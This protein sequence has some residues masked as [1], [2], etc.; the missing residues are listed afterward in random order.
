[1]RKRS[2]VDAY[3]NFQ[4]YVT[5]P[6]MYKLDVFNSR[7]YFE[8]VIVYILSDEVYRL[9]EHEPSERLPAMADM[10]T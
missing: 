9:L 4:V 7:F 2:F 6:G 5:E 1:M 3:G 10:S 8:P